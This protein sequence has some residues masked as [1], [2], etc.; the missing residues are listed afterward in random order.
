MVLAL[1]EIVFKMLAT[2]KSNN[3]LKLPIAIR[4]NTTK[5]LPSFRIHTIVLID[6][7]IKTSSIINKIKSVKLT[8]EI[9]IIFS[10]I[11]VTFYGFLLFGWIQ[12]KLFCDLAVGDV[13]FRSPASYWIES[14]R[15][16]RIVYKFTE[17]WKNV[18]V[19]KNLLSFAK[20]LF[21]RVIWNEKSIR[22][23]FQCVSDY[24]IVFV[25]YHDLWLIWLLAWMETPKLFL[26]AFC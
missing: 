5:K 4:I 11:G 26:T 23:A 6:N 1:N 17:N 19:F 15:L 20:I 18:D 24:S 9:Y 13:R 16:S 14:V 22:N 21:L 25:E 3:L 12:L 2:L 8:R 10:S 7:L